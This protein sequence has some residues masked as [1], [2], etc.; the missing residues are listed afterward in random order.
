MS[1]ILQWQSSFRTYYAD[2]LRWDVGPSTDHSDYLMCVFDAEGEDG[3][4]IAGTGDD[5]ARI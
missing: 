4:R 3:F 2:S 1:E 5:D